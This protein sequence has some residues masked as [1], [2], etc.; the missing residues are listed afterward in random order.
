M[1]GMNCSPAFSFF[2]VLICCFVFFR[3]DNAVYCL[4]LR[5]TG[6]VGFSAFRWATLSSRIIQVS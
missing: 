6:G 2:F 3:A 5:L 1:K 4:H